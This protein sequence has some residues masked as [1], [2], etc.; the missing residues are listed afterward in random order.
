MPVL[1]R[2]KLKKVTSDESFR[3]DTETRLSKSRFPLWS[4]RTRV[5]WGARA[6]ERL[7]GGRG[8]VGADFPTGCWSL[9]DYRTWESAVGPALLGSSERILTKWRALIVP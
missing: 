8:G 6:I 7:N 5:I 2:K 1:C 4:G 3:I 9:A